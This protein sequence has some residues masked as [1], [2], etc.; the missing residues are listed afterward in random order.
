MDRVNE[1]RN[2]TIPITNILNSYQDQTK[3]HP[4]YYF[5]SQFGLKICATQQEIHEDIMKLRRLSDKDGTAYTATPIRTQVS[6]RHQQK[7]K[8]KSEK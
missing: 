3:N 6:R 7:L 4:Y 8:M 5:K 1:I 2:L